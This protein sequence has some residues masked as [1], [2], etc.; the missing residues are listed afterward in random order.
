MDDS[1]RTWTTEVVEA[2]RSI[3]ENIEDNKEMK[4]CIWKQCIYKQNS[5]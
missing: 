2:I 3:E 4:K 1:H 5:E